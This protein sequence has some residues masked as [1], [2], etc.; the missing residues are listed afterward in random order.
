MYPEDVTRESI[1]AVLAGTSPNDELGRDRETLECAVRTLEAIEWMADCCD[2]SREIIEAV[3][4]DPAR[5]PA[6]NAILNR[7]VDAAV[8]GSHAWLRRSREQDKR[9]RE[10]DLAAE[11]KADLMAAHAWR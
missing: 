4:M 10:A 1:R 2:A 9:E 6:A 3:V 5:F 8:N 11:R 7:F